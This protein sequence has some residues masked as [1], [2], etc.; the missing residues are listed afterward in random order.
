[1]YDG[2]YLQAGRDHPSGD[3]AP[4]VDRKDIKSGTPSSALSAARQ[5]IGIPARRHIYLLP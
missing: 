5:C 1:M 2:P 3:S 4:D